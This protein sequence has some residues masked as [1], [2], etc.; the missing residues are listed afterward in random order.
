M[1]DKY[2]KTGDIAKFSNVTSDTVRFYDKEN[3]VSPT[4]VKDNRYRYYTFADALKF[5]IATLLRELNVPLP[6]LRS[7]LTSQNITELVDFHDNHIDV[8]RREKEL[9]EKKISYLEKFDKRLKT[10]ENAPNQLEDIGDESIYI[11]SLLIFSVDERGFHLD[12]PLQEECVG[13]SFWSRTSIIGFVNT[14]EHANIP[15]MGRGFCFNIIQDEGREVEKV[16]FERVLRYNY[17]GNPFKEKDYFDKILLRLD[18]YCLKNN[19]SLDG[20]YYQLYYLCQ[21]TSKDSIYYIH[22]YF[23]LK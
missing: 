11:C 5:D 7:Y 8:L 12:N 9:L 10:F 21:E 18:E 23:P 3:V 20:S 6:Q 16:H 22:I 14:I 17:V 15:T 2:F 13:D 4:I 19:L 1:E